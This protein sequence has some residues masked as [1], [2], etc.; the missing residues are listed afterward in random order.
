VGN[1]GVSN[2]LSLAVS[3]VRRRA[4]LEQKGDDLPLLLD[5]VRRAAAAAAGLLDGEVERRSAA[6]VSAAWI[7]AASQQRFDGCGASGSDGAVQ[8]P[9]IALVG[10]IWVGAGADQAI[11]GGRL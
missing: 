8:R 2:G 1:G 3:V 10:R 4:G 7:G 9:N 5:R 11:D 6:P